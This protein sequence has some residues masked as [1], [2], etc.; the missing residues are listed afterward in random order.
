MP[1]LRISD[2]VTPSFAGQLHATS[3][4]VALRAT[5]GGATAGSDGS[6]RPAPY[7]AQLATT[8]P[9]N[10]SG[11]GS[12]WQNAAAACE[13][14]FP[15][16]RSVVCSSCVPFSKI[17]ARNKLCLIARLFPPRVS[18]GARPGST[19]C[20]TTCGYSASTP[21]FPPWA[22]VWPR[23]ASWRRACLT[24]PA[25]QGAPT[26]ANRANGSAQ[27]P[28][29]ISHFFPTYFPCPGERTG[30]RKSQEDREIERE[31]YTYFLLSFHVLFLHVLGP[32][33]TQRPGG[34]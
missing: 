24:F 14:P 11:C 28:D 30:R 18:A 15:S 31:R 22:T 17:P 23:V 6:A 33:G 9:S 21:Q 13:Q 19:Y 8:G 26:W 27:T 4:A 29:L 3:Q 7:C 32:S 1:V 2:P 16:Q 5:V 12:R 20:T 25:G 34:K 10:G